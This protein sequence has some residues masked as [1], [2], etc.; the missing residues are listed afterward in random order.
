M[1]ANSKKRE[2]ESKDN[3]DWEFVADFKESLEDI[4]AGRIIRVA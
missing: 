1:A 2:N 4:K 3:I